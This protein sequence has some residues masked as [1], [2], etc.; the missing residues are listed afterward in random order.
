M[1]ECRTVTR[2]AYT[3][4]VH[5]CG[6]LWT[7]EHLIY[8]FFFNPDGLRC[9]CLSGSLHCSKHRSV[10]LFLRAARNRGACLNVPGGWRCCICE[11]VGWWDR[12]RLRPLQCTEH[13]ANQSFIRQKPVW[14]LLV[15]GLFSLCSGKCSLLLYFLAISNIVQ[16]AICVYIQHD[17]AF[18]RASAYVDTTHDYMYMCHCA[19]RRNNKKKPEHIFYDLW[20]MCVCL[21]VVEVEKFRSAS[22]VVPRNCD[23]WQP[24]TYPSTSG[25]TTTPMHSQQKSFDLIVSRWSVAFSSAVVR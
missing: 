6:E 3:Y 13:W 22:F 20:Q 12:Q 10:S 1:Q 21:F 4:I 11:G 19:N 14:T 15:Y 16:C 25:A 9:C 7:D 24:G 23:V 8:V 18:P 5:I 2:V 17:L